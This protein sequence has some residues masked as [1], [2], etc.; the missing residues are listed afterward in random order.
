MV[1]LGESDVGLFNFIEGIR[2][3][4]SQFAIERT[5]EIFGHKN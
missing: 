5:K 4:N 1:Q 2:L 3:I